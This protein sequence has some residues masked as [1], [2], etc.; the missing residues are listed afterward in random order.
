MV[1]AYSYARFSTAKQADGDSLRRQFSQA[2]AYAEKYGLVLDTSLVDRGVSSFRGKNRISGA[3]GSFLRMVEDGD[4]PPGSFLLVDS[5]DRLS[6]ENVVQAAH[7]L[8]GIALSGVK[9]VTLNNGFAFDRNAQLPD[10]VIAVAEITRSH[11]ES[12]EKGRKVAEAHGESKRRAREDGTVWSKAGPSWLRFDERTRR[13]AQVQDRVGIIQRIFEMAADHGMGTT[14]IAQRLNRENVAPFKGGISWHGTTVNKIL[15][16]RAVLGEYQ[17]RFANGKP[18]GEPAFGYYGEPVIDPAL[19]YRVQSLLDANRTRGKRP[20]GDEYR[21]LFRG[22]CR[23]S[24]CGGNMR[25]HRRSKDKVDLYECYNMGIGACTNRVRTKSK[26]LETFVL[27][28]IPEL[29]LKAEP[30]QTD[31]RRKLDVANAERR[32][33]ADKVDRLLD[34]I[35]DPAFAKDN[36]LSERYRLRRAQLNTKDI[37]VR[38]LE[39]LL[40]SNRRR[41][42]P[43]ERQAEIKAMRS[44]LSDLTGTALYDIRSR[45]A[46]AIRAVVGHITFFPTGI[47]TVETLGN[48]RLRVTWGLNSECSPFLLDVTTA[49]ENVAGG[50]PPLIQVLVP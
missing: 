12:V 15:R 32:D 36:L 48:T 39:A 24:E 44:L 47:I 16:S 7:T 23:C 25:L 4:V 50:S 31:A 17:P 18:D 6:R 38:S 22:L 30:E 40:E 49:L 43:S 10:V 45:L 34:R 8:L 46:M 41:P 1:K 14:L 9:V 28:H 19:F 29:P 33:L 21:N 26:H 11:A 27:A 13:F 35:E 5:M 20:S 42:E 37:E 3:L 2:F